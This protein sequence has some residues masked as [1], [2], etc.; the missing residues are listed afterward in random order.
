M[1]KK[2]KKPPAGPNMGY[3][4]SFGDTMTALLAF[5]IVLVSLSKE[6]TGANLYSGSGSFSKA[7]RGYG[8]PGKFDSE[9]SN[10][11]FD[12]NETSPL[13][14][15]D[16]P[17]NPDKSKTGAGP[18]AE[19]NQQRVIDREAEDFQR[20]LYEIEHAF[21][22]QQ[23]Q[24]VSHS[25]VFD[26]FDPV[27]SGEDPLPQS[28][29]TILTDSIPLIFSDRYRIEMILWPKV[30][31]PSVIRSNAVRAKEI[32]EYVTMRYGLNEQQQSRISSV[33]RPWLYSDVKR[34]TISIVVSKL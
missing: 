30:P 20:F 18:D 34:P 17:D 29:H 23:K 7:L 21:G 12:L 2:K 26:L 22:I 13:Y 27:G 33:C 10:R 15:V 3:L 5:F 24:Q 14:V 19:A 9:R 6:Q 31:S 25:M 16:D 8:L 32:R 28:V 11:A 1:A 4:V